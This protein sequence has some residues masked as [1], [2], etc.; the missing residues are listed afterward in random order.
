[1]DFAEAVV[2]AKNA[3]KEAE[4]NERNKK[5]LRAMRDLQDAMFY[6]GEAELTLREKFGGVKK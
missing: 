6:L 3:I 2:K 4:R 5:G 1:M